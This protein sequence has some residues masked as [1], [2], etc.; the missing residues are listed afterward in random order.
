M[1]G[2]RDLRLNSKVDVRN[3]RIE[4][5]FW[6]TFDHGPPYEATKSHRVC[7]CGEYMGVSDFTNDRIL[8]SCM[9][10]DFTKIVER[11]NR[12]PS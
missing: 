10:C 6:T 5:P 3:D 8:L 12:S 9:Y 1:K 4:L 7:R 2:N 11:S